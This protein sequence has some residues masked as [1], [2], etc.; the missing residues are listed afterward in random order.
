MCMRG[1]RVCGEGGEMR[2]VGQ[3]GDGVSLGEM[4]GG[5][6]VCRLSGVQRSS[7]TLVM[8]VERCVG[9]LVEGGEA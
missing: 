1:M 2:E 5:E 8:E 7:G 9:G 6:G 3:W 4:A